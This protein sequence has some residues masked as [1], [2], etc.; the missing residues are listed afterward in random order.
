SMR[1]KDTNQDASMS[2]PALAAPSGT[3][4]HDLLAPLGEAA[5]SEARCRE[6]SELIAEIR[7]LKSARNAVILAHNYQRPEIFQV[8]DF[9]GD[10]LELA[11]QATTVEA[12]VI[13][14]CGVHFMAETAKILNPGRR[15]ILPDLRAGCSL[16]DSV[17]A[18][19]LAERKAE[20]RA[21]YP[22]LAVV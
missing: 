21:V 18:E 1:T 17:T 8:A 7:S 3:A 13:V 6:L 2:Q 4:L 22:D 15:V 11:R 10:S 9:V 19:D 20:L 16:A 14:F 12:D 5:Y